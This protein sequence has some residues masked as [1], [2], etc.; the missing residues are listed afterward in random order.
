MLT[1]F[2]IKCRNF[3]TQHLRLA[4]QVRCYI[5]LLFLLLQPLQLLSLF[6]LLQHI[7]LLTRLLVLLSILLLVM[8]AVALISLVVL[9]PQQMR[10]TDGRWATPRPLPWQRQVRE[11]TTTSTSAQLCSLNRSIIIVD[12]IIV[13]IIVISS[14][15]VSPPLS[16][17]TE[18][19]G[20]AVLMS[21]RI[22][23]DRRVSTSAS[24][25]NNNISS[26]IGSISSRSR[27]FLSNGSRQR[28]GVNWPNGTSCILT[29]H[30]SNRSDCLE[31]QA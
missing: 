11:V 21:R 26:I 31:D 13:S 28:C 1:L 3:P 5:P 27:W 19:P 22:P 23:G 16:N 15:S 4:G 2:V 10:Q 8:L 20:K 29:C 25:I 12:V 17:A 14:S 30:P 6:L 9:T 18:E 7:L 24:V